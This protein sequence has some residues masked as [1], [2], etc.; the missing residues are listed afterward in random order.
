MCHNGKNVKSQIKSRTSE[1]LAIVLSSANLAHGP[2]K[3]K[4]VDLLI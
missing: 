4:Y 1:G 3:I 2:R